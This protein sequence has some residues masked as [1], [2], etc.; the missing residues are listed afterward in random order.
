MAEFR[1]NGTIPSNLAKG[2]FV[3]AKTYQAWI[4]FSNKSTEPGRSDANEDVRGMAIKLL[5]VPGDKLLENQ[6]EATTQ[7]FVLINRPVFF[8]NDIRGYIGLVEKA[9][10]GLFRNCR[11]HS[12]L[13]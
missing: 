10:G 11:F 13:A 12:R 8:I 5:G 1:V 6:R 9:E 4:Q 7:D 2:V 3:P